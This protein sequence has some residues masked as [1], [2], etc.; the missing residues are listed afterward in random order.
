MCMYTKDVISLSSVH[1]LVPVIYLPYYILTRMG[2]YQKH[3][4]EKQVL[5]ISISF[6][7]I[8]LDIRFSKE[9]I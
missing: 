1:F 6:T 3:V 2:L 8:P 9:Q 5:Y 4:Y 7:V